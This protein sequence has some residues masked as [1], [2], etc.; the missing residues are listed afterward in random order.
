MGG[1]QG[2]IRSL[3]IAVVAGAAFASPARAEHVMQSIP[4]NSPD[5][6]F[7]QATSF[8]RD[9][10]SIYLAGA[11]SGVVDFNPN[12][13]PSLQASM[14]PE[15]CSFVARYDDTMQLAWFDLF[16]ASSVA[17]D[18]R[19][20][21][22]TGGGVYLLLDFRA[23]FAYR[24]NETQPLYHAMETSD[25]A[26][27][28]LDGEGAYAGSAQLGAVGFNALRNSRPFEAAPG[29]VDFAWTHQGEPFVE[30]GWGPLITRADTSTGIVSDPSVAITPSDNASF[31]EVRDQRPDATGRYVCGEFLGT[32]DFDALHAH[33]IVTTEAG[34]AAW[35][36]FIARY[37]GDGA[38]VWLSTLTTDY[39]AECYGLAIAG[40]GTLWAASD[41]G[42]SGE[43]TDDVSP[44]PVE[45]SAG[46][47]SD[48]LL[49]AYAPDGALISNASLGGDDGTTEVYLDR[50][51]TAA[52]GSVVMTGQ[53]EGTIVHGF[54][55]DMLAES[56]TSDYRD[57][58]VLVAAPD[59]TTRYF[60]SIGYDAGY[61]FEDTLQLTGP[62]QYETI[63][64]MSAPTGGN[65]F[66]DYA[67][68]PE[69][70]LLHNDGTSASVYVR[71]DLDALL[72]NG[73]DEQAP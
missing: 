20:V 25:V 37:D 5:S 55:G 18:Q 63:V 1:A 8:V 66:L 12:G 64:Q 51:E 67:L 36:G 17:L 15:G 24:P 39:F 38:L 72:T 32:V 40:D 16:Y 50:I 43:I 31:A 58:F 22:R 45:I 56:S 49:L 65:A 41:F 4:L 19:L 2:Y 27:V 73:F 54:A 30:N 52:D 47:R 35:A 11:F 26:V 70:A 34:Q 42:G 28:A 57:G 44:L 48:A 6:G 60:G 62:M 10:G 59:L 3:A 68:P 13:A 46:A 33:R 69:Q 7:V 14:C 53:L 71:Y 61:T 9:E 21:A 23:D 29:V